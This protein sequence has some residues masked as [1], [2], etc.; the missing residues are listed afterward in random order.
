[1]RNISINDVDHSPA[2]FSQSEPTTHPVT[3]WPPTNIDEPS[4]SSL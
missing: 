2:V 4:F 3:C 1:M